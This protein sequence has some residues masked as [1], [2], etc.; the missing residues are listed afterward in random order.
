M[1]DFEKLGVTPEL[2]QSMRDL[3]DANTVVIHLVKLKEAGVSTPESDSL[4]ELLENSFI[5]ILVAR[6]NDMIR[7]EEKLKKGL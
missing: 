6:L 7:R 2:T 5:P 4:I 3:A 1:D